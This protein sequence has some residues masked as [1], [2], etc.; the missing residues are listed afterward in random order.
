MGAG[1]TELGTPKHK[2]CPECDGVGFVLG[3]QD[4]RFTAMKTL[5]GFG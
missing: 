3:P 4:H 1:K 5:T 2:L